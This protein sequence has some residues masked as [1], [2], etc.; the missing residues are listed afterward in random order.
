MTFSARAALP[1]LILSSLTVLLMAAVT[2]GILDARGWRMAV[3]TMSSLALASVVLA[4]IGR[5]LRREWLD[6]VEDELLPAGATLPL[7]LTLMLPLLVS[8]DA[9][10]P[11]PSDLA[12][13]SRRAVWFAE[14]LVVARLV[15]GFAI[16]FGFTCVMAQ[17]GRRGRV[18]AV[19]LPIIATV[20]IL[21]LIDWDLA[22][23][24]RW[25][26][27]AVPLVAMVGHLAAALALT[28]VYHLAQR[29]K[30]ADEELV[31]MAAALLSLALL[32]LWSNTVQ[33]LIAWF[34]NLPG[35]A[36]WYLSRF[37]ALP[38]VL[39]A[40]GTVAT[41]AALML[42]WSRRRMV[43]LA[44]ASLMLVA[45]ALHTIWWFAVDSVAT[46]LA[47]ALGIVLWSGWLA[48]LA[49]RHDRRRAKRSW[50]HSDA[51][52]GSQWPHPLEP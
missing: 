44:S 12:D 15:L 48:L 28:F 10:G 45:Y 7:C 19:G 36:G 17:R 33:Y 27:P 22:R 47:F 39:L 25:W 40:A 4:M 38:H 34:G 6:L 29:E 9:V 14:W 11:L 13:T 30:A 51:R 43:M 46:L 52:S 3:T 31:S 41:V 5:L 24:P 16:G 50:R 20:L 23:D 26:T 18:A 21:L 32:A 37:A 42:L 35:G 8:A 1:W 2:A 49:R